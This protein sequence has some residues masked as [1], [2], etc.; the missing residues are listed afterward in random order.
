MLGMGMG[1]GDD[2]WLFACFLGFLFG[3]VLNLEI[4]DPIL[5][6]KVRHMSCAK[7]NEDLSVLK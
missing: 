4:F 3:Q 2:A 5:V 7:E 6:G 1:M